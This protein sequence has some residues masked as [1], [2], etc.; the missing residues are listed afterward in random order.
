[1][2][3]TNEMANWNGGCKLRS[4]FLSTL[5]TQFDRFWPASF[6][7]SNSTIEYELIVTEMVTTV[8]MKILESI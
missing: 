6:S 4:T 5:I 8:A 1:M 2:G 7:S 3:A